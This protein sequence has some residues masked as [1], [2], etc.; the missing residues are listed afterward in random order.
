M[1][2]NSE[3]YE[4]LP[5]ESETLTTEKQVPSK[6][7]NPLT[8]I[9][10]NTFNVDNQNNMVTRTTK[11]LLMQQKKKKKYRVNKENNLNF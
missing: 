6:S 3:E 11:Q 9:N 4:D 8:L 5:I 7:M 10:T 2:T 1:L